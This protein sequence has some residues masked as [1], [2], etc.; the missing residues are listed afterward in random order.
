MSYGTGKAD[1]IRDSNKL[2]EVPLWASHVPATFRS[3]LR[4][5]FDGRSKSVLFFLFL[6]RNST[7]VSPS[8]ISRGIYSIVQL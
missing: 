1:T 3:L 5:E 7:R 2:I 4:A 8:G 6:A